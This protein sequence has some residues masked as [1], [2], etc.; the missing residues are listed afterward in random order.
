M[1]EVL[2]TADMIREALLKPPVLHPI[3]GEPSFHVCTVPKGDTVVLDGNSTVGEAIVKAVM[4]KAPPWEPGP[5]DPLNRR[6]SGEP[7]F[8]LLAR[9][10]LASGMATLWA[11]LRAQRPDAAKDIFK[12]LLVESERLPYSPDKRVAHNTEANKVATAMKLWLIYHRLNPALDEA[13][14]HNESA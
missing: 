1:A 12:N 8:A 4:P 5:N 9:D 13:D 2:I 7:Y 6:R 10:P 14:E 11:A 3:T